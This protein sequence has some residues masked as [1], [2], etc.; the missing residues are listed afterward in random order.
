MYKKKKV[1]ALKHRLHRKKLKEK[2]KAQTP[3]QAPEKE[4]KEKGK[5]QAPEQAP[6]GKL[7]EL[8]FSGQEERVLRLWDCF[9]ATAIKRP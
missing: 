9:P 6:D 1:A 7:E 3:E 4:F 2:R 8:V 5:A